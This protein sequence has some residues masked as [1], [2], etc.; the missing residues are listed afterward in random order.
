MPG[1]RRSTWFALGL[2]MGSLM[3][4]GLALLLAP[5]PADILHHRF[6]TGVMSGWERARV[7]ASGLA[8]RDDPR[9]EPSEA[10]PETE[11]VQ[12]EESDAT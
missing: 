9:A 5:P 8:R 4:S 10:G 11:R 12:Q 1:F 2:V 3:G 6:R 7:V